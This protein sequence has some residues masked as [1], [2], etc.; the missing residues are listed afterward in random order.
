TAPEGAYSYQ[1]AGAGKL[2]RKL[3]L[4][5]SAYITNTFDSVARLLS[6][7]LKNSGNAVLNS[8]AYGYNLGDQRTA[9]TNTAGNYLNYGY[10][11]LGQLKTAF[12][13]ESNGT[14]RVHEQLGYAY[15]PAN[16]PN[17]PTTNVLVQT[18]PVT[19]IN[20]L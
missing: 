10:D 8:H 5:N 18:L 11:P 19:N 12:G 3:S 2:V 9:L 13:S 20:E 7:V 14:V 16:N 17:Y 6:T 1:Y 4:P 15:D